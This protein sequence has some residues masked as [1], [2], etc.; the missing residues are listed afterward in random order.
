M[1][2]IAIIILAAGK[3]TRMKSSLP[4]VLH[5]VCCRPIFSYV[6]DLAKGLRTNKIVTV[7]GYQAKQVKGL[8]GPGI[9]VALQKNLLGTAD[10]VKQALVLLKNF[11]GTV[12]I[13]YGDTP[14][15]K[16]ETIKKLLDYHIK[17][18]VDATILTANADKPEGYGRILRDKYSSI[19]AIVEE[20]DAD[21]FQK[22]IKEIN[23]GILCF[24]KDKLS[25]A[26]NSIKL[27]QRKK[28]Y[29]LTDIIGIFYK[30]GYLVDSVAVT[31]INE[32]LGINTR[33]DLAKA[34]KIMQQRINEKLMLE[35]VSIVDPAT[36]FI[37]YGTKIGRESVIYPFTVIERD[38]KIGKYC[39][40]GPFV[41]LREGTI[42][43]A[44]TVVGNFVEI[45]R[46]KIS[47]RVLI[48]HFSYLGDARIGR[49]VNIGAGTVTANFDGGKKNITV[50]EDKAFIGS[51]TILVAPV[52]VGKAAKT[53]AGAV[54]TKHKNVPAGATVVGIPARPLKKITG[55]TK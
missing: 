46:S 5:P 35:G 2:D 38:V 18:R 55:R 8:I 48:K 11:K 47:T 42:I 30:N 3:S 19:N 50:I 7:L 25:R 20:K 15:L 27:N 9:K 36:C 39:S 44:D 13:L 6:M 34:N 33:P 54:L 40:I 41:H 22:A 24:N 1:K 23:T 32:A 52:K 37:S 21:D 17:N 45:V 53:G 43:E 26:I 31:D 16:K 10:A 51:D 28:E 14:L 29:Y 12:L 49:E 4:K